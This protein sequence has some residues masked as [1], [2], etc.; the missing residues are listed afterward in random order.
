MIKNIKSKR[1]GTDPP[2]NLKKYIEE[3]KKYSNSPSILQ[4]KQYLQDAGLNIN[5]LTKY[6]DEMVVASLT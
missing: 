4:D 6:V 2:A 1:T 3:F 5:K